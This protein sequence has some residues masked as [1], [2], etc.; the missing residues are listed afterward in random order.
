MASAIAGILIEPLPDGARRLTHP[1]GVVCV[2]TA[3]DRENQ[4][5]EIVAEIAIRG[6]QLK[7]FDAEAVEILHGE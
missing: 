6:E 5:A 7:A 2:E 4:R 3:E 1:S